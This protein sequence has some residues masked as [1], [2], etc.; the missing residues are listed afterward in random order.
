MIALLGRAM[1]DGE[2]F[3]RGLAH[4]NAGEFFEAHEAWEQ[5]WLGAADPEKSFLQGMIQ[6]AAAFHHH[7]RGN[8]RGT[9]SLLA[10]G[11]IKIDAF[12]DGHR[13]LALA[14]IRNEA[15]KWI[16][17]LAEGKDLSRQ[18]P[19]RIRLSRTKKRGRRAG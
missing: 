5:I 1:K 17:G 2:P 16:Q 14:E 11:L 12:P 8:S 9:Q 4:F 7:G 3:A 18:Q 13:G 10:A 15:R 6:I 19:P